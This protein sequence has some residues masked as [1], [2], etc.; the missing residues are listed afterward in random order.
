MTP[1]DRQAL[2]DQLERERLILDAAPVAM[3]IIDGEGTLVMVN[4]ECERLFGYEA[5][6]LLGQPVEVLVPERFR[7]GHPGLRHAFFADPQARRMGMGR[8][9]YGRRRDG[10]EIAIELGL[11]PLRVEGSLYVVGTIAD[12]TERRRLETRFRASVE[13]APMAMVMIDREGTIVLLNRECERLFGHRR[14]T[15]LGQPVE[16]L[17]PPRFRAQHPAQ[18]QGFFA[19]PSARRMGAG[20]ELFGL[21]ADGSEFPVEIGLNPISTEDGM[22]VLSAIVDITERKRMDDD[23]RQAKTELEARVADLARTT[24]A[25]ERSNLDLQRFASIASHDLQAP[26]RSISIFSQMIA[27]TSGGK[28]DDEARDWLDRV[29]RGTGRMQDLVASLLAYSRVDSRVEPFAPVD[30]GSLVADVLEALSEGI[31]SSGAVI[32]V[33]DLPTISGDRSQLFQAFQNLIQNALVY[34]GEGPARIDIRATI[35]EGWHEIRVA[36]Q[37]IGIDPRHHQTIFEIFRRLHS[38]D[39][40]PGS[41]IGLAVC[42][43]VML[44]HGGRI[45]VASTAGQGATFI[46]TLPLATRP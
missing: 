8:D 45:A 21:R 1:P 6:D 25:L 15:L 16:V 31:R 44:R 5:R 42:R 41:G 43:R 18:R 24:E 34:R 37:G 36:D 9:L 29:I 26:L 30:L 20:R 17:V 23:L 33:G 28:L 22:Y 38:Q 12:I 13:S 14:E 39:S 35:R 27:E 4:A 11:S 40:I 2:N 46:L 19:D 7:A 32:T 3:L 10:S